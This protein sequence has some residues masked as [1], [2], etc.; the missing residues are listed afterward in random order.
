MQGWSVEA[1][2]FQRARAQPEQWARAGLSAGQGRAAYVTKAPSA[3][4]RV[5]VWARGW[6]AS[7]KSNRAQAALLALC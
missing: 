4:E 3:A 5:A 1:K 7:R 6:P 2:D